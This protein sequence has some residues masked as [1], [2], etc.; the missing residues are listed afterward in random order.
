MGKIKT[1][2]KEHKKEIGMAA[3]SGVVVAGC[4]ILHKKV[5]T[6]YAMPRIKFEGNAKAF[7]EIIEQVDKITKHKDFG[8][9]FYGGLSVADLGNYGEE[10]LDLYSECGLTKDTLVRGVLVMTD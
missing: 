3:V 8:W 2:V 4:V 7:K 5:N 10:L 6:N 1:F 9:C